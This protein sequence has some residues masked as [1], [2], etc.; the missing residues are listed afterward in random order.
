MQVGPTRGLL[1]GGVRQSVGPTPD[2]AADLQ[3]LSGSFSL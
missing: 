3:A 2:V 1:N